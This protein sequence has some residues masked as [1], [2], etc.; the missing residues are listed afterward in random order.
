M[1]CQVSRWF[2]CQAE[3]SAASGP[4]QDPPGSRSP[5]DFFKEVF[6]AKIAMIA[7]QIQPRRCAFAFTFVEAVFTIAVI[8]IM[9]SLAVSAISNASRDANR[10]V[11]RQQQ[12]AINEALAAWVMSQ[13]RVGNTAQLQSVSNIRAGYNALSTSSARFSLLLPNS[14]ASDPTA[15]AGFLDQTTADHFLEYTTSTDRL[16]SASLESAKQY[17]S[18]PNWT[19]GDFPRAELVN[20]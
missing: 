15:R 10:I 2:S 17:L 12:A 9:A 20:E 19:D 18:L 8:G 14:A 11:A 6:P 16:K 7:S 1:L 3:Q 5:A 13:T 4:Y